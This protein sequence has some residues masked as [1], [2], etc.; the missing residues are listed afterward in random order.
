MGKPI[1]FGIRPEHLSDQISD[2]NHI[3]VTAEI[4]EPMGSESIVYLKAGTA[5]LIARVPGEHHY[6][7]GEQLTV[8]PTWRKSIFSTV[9]PKK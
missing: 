5:N 6:H 1:L 8:Q 4:S 9:R 7:P 2:P 3:P